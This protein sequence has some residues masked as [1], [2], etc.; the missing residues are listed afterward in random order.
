LED[1][2]DYKNEIEDNS[3]KDF[4][5]VLRPKVLSDFAGQPQVIENLEIFVKAAK[6]RKNLSTTFCFTVLLDLE[7]RP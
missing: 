4:D 2:F 6:Q 3:E 1:S 5:K 7:K